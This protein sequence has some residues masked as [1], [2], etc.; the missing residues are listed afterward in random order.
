MINTKFKNDTV[1]SLIMQK[2]LQYRKKRENNPYVRVSHSKIH[3]R[4]V[5]AKIRI[6]K[7]TR[8]IEY[9]G[10]KITKEETEK[11]ENQAMEKFLKNPDKYIATY[12]FYLNERHNI[13]GDVT[14]NDAKYI[15]HSCD[16]NCRY[17]YDNDTIWIV[18]IKDI[19]KDEEITYNY[20]FDIDEK[21]PEDI[22][23]HPCYCN[24]ERCVGY[25]SSEKHWSRV[26]QILRKKS[27]KN[28]NKKRNVHS[29]LS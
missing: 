26:K 4:G 13:N 11:K 25:I 10:R 19:K 15:N 8:I 18:S 22:I 7:N 28:I 12:I 3:R 29:K 14:N 17:E 23:N 1:A 16:P 24:S 27:L 21:F 6:P 20:D 2:K 9:K 5:F